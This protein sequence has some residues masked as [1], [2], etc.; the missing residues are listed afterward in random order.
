[1]SLCCSTLCTFGV[2]NVPRWLFSMTGSNTQLM[3]NR[4]IQ[5]IT[6]LRWI[7]SWHVNPLILS[8]DCGWPHSPPGIHYE[9]ATSQRRKAD[10]TEL[11]LQRLNE[12]GFDPWTM[13]V[14]GNH[15][16]LRWTLYARLQ[17]PVP[18]AQTNVAHCIPVSIASK[19]THEYGE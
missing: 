13:Q 17:L 19:H 6:C 2:E 3:S 11:D 12:V 18:A 16:H 9:S 14:G 5:S 15:D 7:L 4:K 8:G 10:G 1:M